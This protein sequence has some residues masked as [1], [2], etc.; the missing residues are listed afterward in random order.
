MSSGEKKYSFYPQ[1]MHIHSIYEPFASMEGHI[2]HARDLGMKYIWFTDHDIRMGRKSWEFDG[3]DFEEGLTV[4]RGNATYGFK[5]GRVDEACSVSWSEGDAY[6]GRGAMRLSAADGVA[7]AV[8]FTYKKAHCRALLSELKL[9]LAYK[10]ASSDPENTRFIVDVTLSQRPPEDMPAHLLFV[11][12]Y[13]DGLL[14]TPHTHAV[15]IPASEE[16]RC[17]VFDLSAEAITEA[18]T[19]HGIGGLDNGF[20]ALQI[21]VEARSGATVSAWVDELTKSALLDA[22]ETYER[23]KEVAKEVGAKYG[24]TPF[25]ATE[26]SLAGMHKNYFSD[27]IELIPYEARNYKVKH[28]EAC[29]ELR[30]IGAVFAINHPFSQVDYS[31]ISLLNLDAEVEKLAE[32]FIEKECF[33]ASLMEV[34]FPKGRYLPLWCHLKLWDRLSAAGVLVT[35]YGSSDAHANDCGW[36]SGNNF[37]N[38]IGVD[39]DIEAP[40][41]SDFAEA[42]RCGRLYTGNPTKIKGE[43]VFDAECGAVMGEIVP[44]SSEERVRFRM[45]CAR[46]GWRVIWIVNGEVERECTLEDGSFYG[47][48][49]VTPLCELDFVRVEIYDEGGKCLLLTNPIYFSR[50]ANDKLPMRRI[51]K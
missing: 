24:V 48:L 46:R 15:E 28:E 25:V 4:T 37:T 5:E 6:R 29:E 11:S 1:H 34:G 19:A 21:R 40:T 23:Q 2:R 13:T 31:D 30:R 36:Y 50:K 26:I 17:G 43:V 20:S 32:S 10:I 27:E 47:E 18:A 38:W 7:E 42:M 44:S 45:D 33:G 14:D 16:W 8:M 35:G 51:K 39:S 22:Q 3:F 12:G 41:A 49:T 9:G